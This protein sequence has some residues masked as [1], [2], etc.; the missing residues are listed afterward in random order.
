MNPESA[1]GFRTRIGLRHRRPRAVRDKPD[2]YRIPTMS[3]PLL[4]R[5]GRVIDPSRAFD[6]VT[7]LWLADGR[8]A[9]TGPRPPRVVGDVTELDCTGLIVAPGLIDMHVHLREPGR[10]EDE[11]IATGTAA[12]VAGGVTSVACMP[13]TEPALD[14]RMAVEFVIHQAERAGFCNVF[15][16]GAVTKTREGKELAELG[17][18]SRSPTTA[19][20]CTR[21]RSCGGRWNTARCSTRRCWST[22]RSSSSRRGA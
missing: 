1:V 9:G 20:R 13:N 15:P 17:G 2:S 11:T 16:V 18:R 4:L 12:A 10:E 5:N 3:F 19:R 6:Q 22:P 21:P 14:T 7:D 8:V